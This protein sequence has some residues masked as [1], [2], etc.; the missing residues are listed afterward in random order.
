MSTQCLGCKHFIAF[1][2]CLAFPKGIPNE[3]ITGEAQHDA[4]LPGQ[5][6]TYV[7][8]FDADRFESDSDEEN[9]I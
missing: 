2:Y 8:E 5:V 9:A 3:Q 6:G 1:G 7:Y 4:V